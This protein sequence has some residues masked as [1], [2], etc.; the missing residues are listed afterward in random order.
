MNNTRLTVIEQAS[1]LYA[2]KGYDGVS[3]RDIAAATGITPASLYHHFSDKEQLVRESLAYVFSQRAAPLETL[4]TSNQ[5]PTEKLRAFVNWF[6]HL[7]CEDKIFTSLLARELLDADKARLAY[8]AET[9]LNRPF[10]LITRIFGWQASLNDPV[11]PAISVISLIFGHVQMAAVL[12]FLPG[13]RARHLAPEAI[14]RQVFSLLSLT[15]SDAEEESCER[16]E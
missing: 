8:L 15:L 9:V 16:N 14:A 5:T 11:M 4:L 6:A 12:P 13:I 3:M 7:M 10:S 2:E 1:R